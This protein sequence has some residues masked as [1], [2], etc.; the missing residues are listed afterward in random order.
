MSLMM[1]FIWFD[2]Y[3]M[4]K[5]IVYDINFF[6][7]GKMQYFQ[8]FEIGRVK[9]VIEGYGYS[10]DF[11]Y[12]VLKELEFRFGKFFVVKVILNRFRKIVCV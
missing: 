11:Y 9:F 4:F 10:G 1:I 5:L 8:N 6:F 12:E 3:L 7:D 2:W